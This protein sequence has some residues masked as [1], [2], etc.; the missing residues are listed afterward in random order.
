MRVLDLIGNVR[1]LERDLHSI[2][3]TLKGLHN[4]YKNYNLDEQQ[5]A[6]FIEEI[7]NDNRHSVKILV[8]EY[9]KLKTELDNLLMMDIDFVSNREVVHG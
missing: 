2:F 9:I 7:K 1:R 3:D 5:K 8:Q 4:K 6:Q